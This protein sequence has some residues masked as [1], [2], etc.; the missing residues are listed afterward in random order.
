MTRHPTTPQPGEA[1]SALPNDAT[2]WTAIRANDEAHIELGRI[3]RWS[4]PGM[5]GVRQLIAAQRK[6]RF[7]SENLEKAIATALAAARREGAAE[8]RWEGM[9]RAA[10]EVDM[11][12]AIN[13]GQNEHITT[14]WLNGCRGGAEVIR[15]LIGQE[16]YDALEAGRTLTA[17]GARDEGDQQ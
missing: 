15:D 8:V 3:E 16:R 7:A 6:A 5:D 2:F 4:E 14:A 10:K 9:E 1:D 12:A 13:E 11:F 17:A